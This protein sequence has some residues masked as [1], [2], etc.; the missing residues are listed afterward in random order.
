MSTAYHTSATGIAVFIAGITGTE[1]S[2]TCP[3]LVTEPTQFKQAPCVPPS[4]RHASQPQHGC[5]KMGELTVQL[6][7]GRFRQWQL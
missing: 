6:S 1:F 2:N 7:R 3:A 4:G 5:L